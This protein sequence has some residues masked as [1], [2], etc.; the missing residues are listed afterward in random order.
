[1]SKSLLRISCTMARASKRSNRLT[2]PRPSGRMIARASS[3]FGV[4]KESGEAAEQNSLIRVLIMP[5]SKQ[6][7]RY[8]LL[9]N[10]L[11]HAYRQGQPVSKQD[12]IKLLRDKE[13]EKVSEKTIQRDLAAFRDVLGL[14]VKYDSRSGGYC[15][16]RQVEL[17]DLPPDLFN[18][19]DAR[20]LLVAERAL[21]NFEGTP[22][23]EPMQATIRRL[24][25]MLSPQSVK[26]A[27]NLFD[28][29]RFEGTRA[30]SIPKAIWEPLA[31]ALA[32]RVTLKMTYRSQ[33]AG[34][35]ASRLLDPYALV[36]IDRQWQI[37]G[38]SHNR[39]EVRTFLVSR[40]KQCEATVD[41]F[42]VRDNWNV[43]EYLRDSVAGQQATGPRQQVR[44]RFK[45]E[46]SVGAC[47]QIW[48]SNQQSETDGQGRL[49]VTFTTAAQYEVQRQVLGWGGGCELLEPKAWREAIEQAANR[50][51]QVNR[52]AAE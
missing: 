46:A 7:K 11:S 26:D 36:V 47:D 52:G 32:D 1:M 50:A 39:K 41:S 49:I 13:G 14:P 19:S 45:P 40:I 18:E 22:W 3:S 44:L 9:H 20:V 5:T 51:S 38:W 48:H 25:N 42:R 21:S 8:R 2:P 29:I 23:Y 16:T 31:E 34:K 12:L 37:I 10:A 15:Y 28:L 33:S 6:H 35:T 17:K 4:S 30:Q 24:I 43:D 27:K